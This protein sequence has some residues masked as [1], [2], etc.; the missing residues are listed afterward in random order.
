MISKN[1]CTVCKNKYLSFINKIS[2]WLLVSIIAI[3]FIPFICLM[4]AYWSRIPLI[5]KVISIITLPIFYVSWMMIL[6]NGMVISPKGYIWFIPDIRIKKIL[7]SEVARIVF[8]MYEWE[9]G[10][11]SVLVKII[12]KDGRVFT[13]DYAR[14]F[15]P[16]RRSKLMQSQ[17]TISKGK[18]DDICEQLLEWDICYINIVD[19]N[20]Q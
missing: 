13:K 9:N 3:M 16:H 14:A 11:Y 4:F 5:I 12:Y 19:R 2:I 15:A 17:Y 18:V 6:L 1:G 7:I 10:K 8:N 20:K